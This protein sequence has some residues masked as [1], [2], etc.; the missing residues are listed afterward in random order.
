MKKV[1]VIRL[2]FFFLLA[3]TIVSCNNDIEDTAATEL[4]GFSLPEK[5][6]GYSDAL[7]RNL[8]INLK[9]QGFTLV[10]VNAENNADNQKKQIDALLNIG[11]K[12]IIVVAPKWD[13][14]ENITKIRGKK[15]PLINALN[16]LPNL[17]SINALVTNNISTEGEFAANI[18]NELLVSG[19]TYQVLYMNSATSEQE[20]VGWLE[21]LN[22]NLKSTVTKF[23][24]PLACVDSLS[25]LSRART[26]LSR[27]V[28]ACVAFD[29]TSLQGFV[30]ALEAS[31]KTLDDVKIIAF[32]GSPDSKKMLK[33][34]RISA[35]ISRS[36]IKISDALAGICIDLI[37]N[38]TVVKETLIEGILITAQNVDQYDIN[39]WE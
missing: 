14:S 9:D 3:V 17:D 37:N 15:I 31:D 23:S 29:D 19:G 1:N 36:P 32:S 22:A 4:I 8:M 12:A 2:L 34:G 16:A 20:R 11:I 6:D 10:V 33:E 26:I 39:S 35:I 25:A 5:A 7:V 27:D 18:I 24:N 30:V 28:Q 13:F 38:Q 21:Y